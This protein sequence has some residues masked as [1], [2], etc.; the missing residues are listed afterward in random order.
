MMQLL[1]WIQCKFWYEDGSNRPLSGGKVYFYESGT[2]IN[3]PTWQNEGGSQN[4]NPVI[5]DING[6]AQIWLSP[7]IVYDIK[8]TDADNADVFTRE[9]VTVGNGGGTAGGDFIKKV[10]NTGVSQVVNTD[11]KTTFTSGSTQF[12]GNVYW[13]DGIISTINKVTD[14]S[15]NLSSDIPGSV[16]ITLDGPSYANYGSNYAASV[17][18]GEQPVVSHTDVL[19]SSY[20]A[21]GSI[22]SITEKYDPNTNEFTVY[23]SVHGEGDR[24][25]RISDITP[26]YIQSVSDTQTVDLTVTGNDLTADV[27]VSADANNIIEVHTDGLYATAFQTANDSNTIDFGTSGTSFTGEVKIATDNANDLT[28]GTDGLYVQ[29]TQFI[30]G[31]WSGFDVFDS[32]MVN[33][34]EVVA[35][36]VTDRAEWL[37]VDT[38]VVPAPGFKR[39]ALWQTA[40]SHT[41]MT[42][43]ISVLINTLVNVPVLAEREP[44]A[45]DIAWRNNIGVGVVWKYK[46]ENLQVTLIPAYTTL[47]FGMFIDINDT[48]SSMGVKLNSLASQHPVATW[49]EQWTVGNN[50]TSAIP[51]ET[52]AGS[53]VGVQDTY[54]TDLT[55][56][57]GIISSSPK[58]RYESTFS[59][60]V[61][62]NTVWF[63]RCPIQF[64]G[65]AM[66][67]R[68]EI[69]VDGGGSFIDF[70][71]DGELSNAVN[72]GKGQIAEMYNG[73]VQ[74][75]GFGN[76]TKPVVGCDGT[77]FYFGLTAPGHTVQFAGE[78]WFE[79]DRPVNFAN[80]S[81]T[82]PS[83]ATIDTVRLYDS[84]PV[85]V[86]IPLSA[87]RENAT[88]DGLEAPTQ[89]YIVNTWAEFIQVCGI[90]VGGP[91]KVINIAKDLPID[92]TT[93]ITI[94]GNVYV[95]GAR[96]I[97]SQGV[98][99]TLTIN[100]SS[101]YIRFY[102]ELVW[103]YNTNTP[104]TPFAGNAPIYLRNFRRI[105]NAYAV[106][107]T[108]TSNVT[109]EYIDNGGTIANGTKAFWDNTNAT[110]VT[111]G[112]ALTVVRENA[113]SSGIQ[114]DTQQY[115]VT[116]L[117]ELKTALAINQA[118]TIYCANQITISANDTIAIA[119]VSRVY[120]ADILFIDSETIAFTGMGATVAFYN[121]LNFINAI[122]VTITS[123]GG[124]SLYSRNIRGSG[125][126]VLTLPSNWTYEIARNMSVVNGGIYSFWDNTQNA[127]VGNDALA[128]GVLTGLVLSGTIGA[129]SVS[130]SAGQ[131]RVVNNNVYPATVSNVSSPISSI[132]VP[133]GTGFRNVYIDNAGVVQTS[134][135]TLL[136]PNLV[137]VLGFFTFVG[138]TVTSVVAD[139]IPG[140]SQSIFGLDLSR[141]LGPIR[142]GGTP[143]FAASLQL[144][145]TAC[146]LT[147]IGV[148]YGS[149]HGLPNAKNY[150]AIAAPA[151]FF[152]AT[153]TT[154]ITPAATA[155]IPGS[156][157]VAGTVTPVPSPSTRF[158]NQ[159]IFMDTS[160]NRYIQYGQ[161]LYNTIAEATAAIGTETFTINPSFVS[162]AITLIGVISVKGNAT[163][164]NDTAQCIFQ[165]ASK[166]GEIQLTAGASG[167]APITGTNLT[168]VRLNSTGTAAADT[169]EYIVN[170]ITELVTALGSAGNKRI[171]IATPITVGTT[172]PVTLTGQ[173][174]V[175]GSSLTFTTLGKIDITPAGGSS[176]Y[177]YNDI[178]VSGSGTIVIFGTNTSTSNFIRNITVGTGIVCQLAQAQYERL[179]GSGSITTGIQAYWD[180]TYSPAASVNSLSQIQTFDAVLG[181]SV[182]FPSTWKMYARR[183]F[184]TAGITVNNIR[185]ISPTGLGGSGTGVRGFIGRVT[186]ESGGNFTVTIDGATANYT[187]NTT[188]DVTIPL[189]APVSYVQGVQYAIILRVDKAASGNLVAIVPSTGVTSGSYI[190]AGEN[191]SGIDPT[192]GGTTVFSAGTLAMLPWVRC[193]S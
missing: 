11:L 80:W 17:L 126:Q 145:F 38:G 23:D 123:T 114:A 81:T 64:G 7:D 137:C 73:F 134:T 161:V 48:V 56:N 104:N 57:S 163:L 97:W 87:A 113:T 112:N 59:G 146:T 157:D 153:Q 130:V 158:T 179:R 131:A 144:A 116:T 47:G 83:I 3:A 119:S 16:E 147:R 14:A 185:L 32:G 71:W 40:P 29:D 20:G 33:T 192:I 174:M 84:A 27:K 31:T 128:T 94:N 100:G 77:Y 15:D 91:S 19:T 127:N 111:S 107:V 2:L 140:Y 189:T 44:I 6:E 55:L 67:C 133:T 155:V 41:D 4:P 160:G 65:D 9:R 102:N 53:V 49:L 105:N 181:Q 96:L 30:D 177:W 166:I 88:G 36:T 24:Y 129:T 138:G 109:Y 125:A 165:Q 99:D 54:Y 162:P 12:E 135:S 50:L 68:A 152:Y 72:F 51:F 122:N 183:D 18:P 42:D 58:N 69:F 25:A 86:G 141:A 168:A 186:A 182:T 187:L 52:N 43:T 193:F 1:P 117:A 75:R 184:L 143:T 74:E 115:V 151:S 95:Y 175:T 171:E 66:R 176:V 82:V 46:P 150:S 92:G 164:L 28:L 85:T 139:T 106:N 13:R 26:N 61:S 178:I 5:L 101:Y 90:N 78:H 70:Q 136:D 89:F 170:N 142:Q 62:G 180:N 159:R 108:L 98:P 8:V 169:L 124:M 63:A 120:G 39:W 121:D 148:N 79:T 172:Y 21:T 191:S 156:Y 37:A 35:P 34:P 76:T 93:A 188:G 167:S 118:K 149:S 103:S 154:V 22:A 190:T 132:P 10:T 45:F 60:V 173:N 110:Y